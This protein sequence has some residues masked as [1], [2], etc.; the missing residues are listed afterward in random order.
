MVEG[1]PR[2]LGLRSMLGELGVVTGAVELLADSSAAKSFVSRRGLGKM[3]HVDVKFL[4]LQESVILG[5]VR[6]IKVHGE[7]NPADLLTKYL[8]WAR[9]QMLGALVGVEV[10]TNLSACAEGD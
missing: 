9:I 5:N 4:W 3:R 6:V 2:G 7:C 10:V 1:A 8:E